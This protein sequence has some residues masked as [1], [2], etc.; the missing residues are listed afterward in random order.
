MYSFTEENYLKAIYKLSEAGKIEVSTNAIADELQT[1]AASVSD[2]LRKL[3]E[4]Q[5]LDY[6]KYKGVKLTNSGLK[7]ALAVVRKHR[8]W[9]VFLHDKLKFGWDEVHE[10]AEQLEHIQSDVLI[11]RLDEYLGFPEFDP[12]GDPIPDTE[13]KMKR[14]NF[15]PLA[16]ISMQLN[17]VLTGVLDHNPDFLKMLDKWGLKIGSVLSLKERNE[18]DGSIEL[19]IG[20]EQSL[21][22]AEKTASKILVKEIK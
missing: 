11:E 5:L 16:T 20:D 19:K 2:M 10:I 9:E 15:L 7:A 22:V 12:H 4:K 13:G 21:F 8:L 18:F 3:S 17:Y 6:E 1:R 14:L